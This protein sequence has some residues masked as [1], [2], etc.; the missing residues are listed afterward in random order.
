M[1][2]ESIHDADQSMNICTFFD[3]DLYEDLDWQA[4][5][6]TR[7]TACLEVTSMR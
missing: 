4:L 3:S 7:N 1:K 6:N 5:N 2:F